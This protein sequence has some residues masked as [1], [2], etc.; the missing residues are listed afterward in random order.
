MYTIPAGGKLR[1]KDSKF[2]T[3]SIFQK[4][5]TCPYTT[6]Q[7]HTPIKR[8]AGELQNKSWR[9]RGEVCL[10]HLRAGLGKRRTQ[11]MLSSVLLTLHFLN[12]A[13]CTILCL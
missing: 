13:F 4:K 7:S 10:T 1:Q 6:I 9:R 3:P 8:R 12:K 2:K 5:P 11:L